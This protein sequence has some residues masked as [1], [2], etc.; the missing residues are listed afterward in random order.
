MHQRDSCFMLQVDW[1]V[2]Q[3]DVTQFATVIDVKVSEMIYHPLDVKATA[4]NSVD[5]C[6][7]AVFALVQRYMT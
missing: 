2:Y 7:R 3:S 6:V 1:L 5:S 4:I